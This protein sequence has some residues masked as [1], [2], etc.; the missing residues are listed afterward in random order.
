MDMYDVTVP[1]LRRV[2]KNI[3]RWLERA[4]QHETGE[5]L[6]SNRLAPDQFPL[7]KQV[8]TACDNAKMMC[9]R[10]AGRAWPTHPDTETTFAQLQERIA[11]VV[12]FLDTFGPPHFAEANERTIT[13]PWMQPGQHMLA[14]AYLVQ[15]ALPNFY[16]HVVTAYAIMRNAGVQLGKMDFIGPIDIQS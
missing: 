16:F 14:S 4:A 1:Q 5:K 6:L 8:Q 2:L 13:L 15:F 9:G 3:S 7:V 11:S 12:G 10:L